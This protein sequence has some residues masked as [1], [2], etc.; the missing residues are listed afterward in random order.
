MNIS[1]DKL[2][3]AYYYILKHSYGYLEELR[4]IHPDI[5]DYFHSINYISTGIDAIGR[6]RY[7][8]TEEGAQH[9]RVSYIAISAKKV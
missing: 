4:V 1:D 7:K 5:P 9:A 3:F 2:R 8:I 6:E